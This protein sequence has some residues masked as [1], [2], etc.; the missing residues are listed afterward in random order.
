LGISL[1][2]LFQPFEQSNEQ[3]NQLLQKIERN[4]KKEMLLNAFNEILDT[5]DD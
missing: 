3:M 1:T 2:T 5:Y 4:P